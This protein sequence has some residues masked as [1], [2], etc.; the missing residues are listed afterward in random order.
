M[1]R[2]LL[3]TTALL[4][5]CAGLLAAVPTQTLQRELD[6][7]S[8]KISGARTGMNLRAAAFLIDKKEYRI[9]NAAYS[10][11]CIFIRK[12]LNHFD[13]PIAEL[14]AKINLL[15]H[16]DYIAQVEKYYASDP[17]LQHAA[18][19][20][21]TLPYYKKSY[22]KAKKYFEKRVQEEKDAYHA[23]I[24]EEYGNFWGLFV[25][26]HDTINK[27]SW[28]PLDKEYIELRRAH[29]KDII[30]YLAF[31]ETYGDNAVEHLDPLSESLHTS[32]KELAVKLQPAIDNYDMLTSAYN[33][34][35]LL[36]LVMDIPLASNY[37]HSS[38]VYS[39]PFASGW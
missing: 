7:V 38:E 18:V 19:S 14:Q 5:T 30:K 3:T 29:E 11:A 25:R 23:M 21:I 16:C 36:G 33:T 9:L 28:F 31:Q 13:A 24:E 34:A 1:K 20:L 15:K 4:F 2:V 35:R 26:L 12:D 32:I 10:A 17:E 6:Q 8:R 27:G 22:K 37:E 39:D